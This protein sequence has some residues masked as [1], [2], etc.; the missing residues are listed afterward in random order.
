MHCISVYMSIFL[1]GHC[2]TKALTLV[3]T[4][5][6]IIWIKIKDKRELKDT[7]FMLNSHNQEGFHSSDPRS[8]SE[9]CHC[10]GIPFVRL[11]RPFDSDSHALT[12]LFSMYDVCI[13]CLWHDITDL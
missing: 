10:E 1:N 8:M 12:N 13:I 2:V 6:I 9:S 11:H 7:D 4:A 5:H 3:S